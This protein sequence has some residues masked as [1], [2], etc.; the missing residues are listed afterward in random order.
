MLLQLMGNEVRTANDGPSALVVAKAFRPEVVLLDIGLPG[1]NGYEVAR[2]LRQMPETE[3]ALLV[4]QT[5]WG[6]E[7]DRRR[8][9]ETGFNAHLVKP[10]D[11]ED[12]Q[13]LLASLGT[14]QR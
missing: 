2:A 5:G 10:I 1:M 11:S 4:A 13:K 8:S 12:L 6:Q 3:H 14:G 9:A 7:E